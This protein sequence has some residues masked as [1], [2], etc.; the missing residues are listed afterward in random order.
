MLNIF[1]CTFFSVLY[2][3]G[4]FFIFFLE[5]FFWKLPH[6]KKEKEK[7]I[8]F[9]FFNFF[10]TVTKRNN[11]IHFALICLVIAKNPAEGLG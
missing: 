4:S 7:N 5:H 3:S 9:Y 2:F 10:L 6:A 1:F 11:K 8:N